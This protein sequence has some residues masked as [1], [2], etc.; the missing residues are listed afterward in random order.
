MNLTSLHCEQFTAFDELTI[1]FCPGI[2]VFVGKNGTGKTHLLKLAYAACDI[3]KSKLGLA[4]KINRLFL[5]SGGSIG[6][7]V[8]RRKGSS[9]SV[10]EVQRGQLKLHVS[11]SNHAERP[12]SATVIGEEKW[13][14][15]P[16]ESVFIPAQE[17][18]SHGPGFLSLYARREIH[19][20]ETYADILQR[21]YLPLLRGPMDRK[22]RRLLT[23]LEKTITGKVIVKGDEF[24]LRNRQGNLEFSLLAEGFRKLG[25]L[26][27]LMQNG[28][29]TQGSVLFWDEPEANLNPKMLGPLMEVLLE[30]QR[31]GVQVFIATHDYVVLKELD[32]RRR[33]GDQVMYHSLYHDSKQRVQCSPASRYIEIEPNAIAETFSELYDR[34]LEHLLG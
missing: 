16:V 20:D 7:L 32:Q 9:R 1:E 30:L 19:F 4:E 14:A 10:I 28:T 17:M 27:R 33:S 23:Q 15:E 3:T 25:L 12:G 31:T 5:P 34:E 22:R 2:N 26:W 21:A 13:A 29:L 11:F 8:R 24:F 6:R 18:L